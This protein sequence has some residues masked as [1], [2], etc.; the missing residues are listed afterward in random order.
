MQAMQLDLLSL[1]F[2]AKWPRLSV[3]TLWVLW[4]VMIVGYMFSMF[5]PLI[6]ST[7]ISLFNT[8]AFLVVACQN[9]RRHRC[10]SRVR[11]LL[12]QEE[13]IVTIGQRTY[14]LWGDVRGDHRFVLGLVKGDLPLPPPLPFC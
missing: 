1:W 14:K 2:V 9:G 4:F 3:F 11:L 6:V 10:I 5:G 13:A 7:I 12:T 8:L